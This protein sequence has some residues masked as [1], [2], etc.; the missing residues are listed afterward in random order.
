MPADNQ[1]MENARLRE[2]IKK[3]LKEI[4]EEDI[5]KEGSGRQQAAQSYIDV[6]NRETHG[7]TR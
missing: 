2:M 4:E 6:R 5:G 7:E 1:S 3:L